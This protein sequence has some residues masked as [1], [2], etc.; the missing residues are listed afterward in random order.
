MI[1]F[2]KKVYFLL[3]FVKVKSYGISYSV[4]FAIPY[5]SLIDTTYIN[6]IFSNNFIIFDFYDIDSCSISNKSQGQLRQLFNVCHTN[7]MS[8][9][10]FTGYSWFLSKWKITL[11]TL[12]GYLTPYDKL[13]GINFVTQQPLFT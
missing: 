7:H 8:K 3:F 12:W 10:C 1:S 2:A 5:M 9:R 6:F 11:Q 13:N 4:L